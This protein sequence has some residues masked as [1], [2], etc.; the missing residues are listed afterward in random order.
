MADINSPLGR[1]KLAMQGQGNRVYTIPDATQMSAES[2]QF[3]DPMD[4]MPG[5]AMMSEEEM[6][7]FQKQRQQV[8]QEMPAQ[9]ISRENLERMRQESKNSKLEINAKA[10][11]RIEVLL[12]LK[13]KTKEVEV[14][15]VKFVLKTLKHSEYQEI[16]T[17]LSKIGDANNFVISLE[18]QIQSLAR[19]ITHIDGIPV[20]SVLNAE[21]VDDI[22]EYFREFD[23]E[24]IEQLYNEFK[25][26]KESNE[27]KPEEEKEVNEDLKK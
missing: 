12:G 15:G 14:E 26:L 25:A 9:N 1:R 27:V 22:I 4:G 18:M 2:T 6:L 17:S 3:D 21:S 24:L 8:R 7:R 13:R 23:N 11:N 16:F 10:R 19:S 20:E 5:P